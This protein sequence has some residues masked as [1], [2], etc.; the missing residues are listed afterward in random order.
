MPSINGG[1]QMKDDYTPESGFHKVEL[2]KKFDFENIDVKLYL[3]LRA[4]LPFAKTMAD[5]MGYDT[6]QKEFI[7][8]ALAIT[9]FEQS[10]GPLPDWAVG[11][12]WDYSL[13]PGAQLCTK[14]GRRTGNAH[15]I[16]KGVMHSGNGVYINNVYNCL[17]DVGSKFTFTEVELLAAFTIGDWISDPKRV[18]KD[19]DRHG[20]YADL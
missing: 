16:T 7:Q 9:E 15:I 4:L 2:E 8:S 5:K 10:H 13:V 3:A 12:N 20:H 1:D 18:L 19:F 6:E 11:R 14:D 17:T